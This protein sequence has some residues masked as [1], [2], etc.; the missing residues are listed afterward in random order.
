MINHLFIVNRVLPF[1]FFLLNEEALPPFMARIDLNL[2]LASRCNTPQEL[3][4]ITIKERI[5]PSYNSREA[6]DDEVKQYHYNVS[7]FA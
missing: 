2:I 3:D 6:T 7:I 1:L 5:A 4:H